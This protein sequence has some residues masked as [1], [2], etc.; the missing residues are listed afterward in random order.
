V[1]GAHSHRSRAS[2]STPFW[3]RATL[4]RG[5]DL[6]ATN[7][8][9][10]TPLHEAARR[11]HRAIILLLLKRGANLNARNSKNQ[12]ARELACENGLTDVVW[13]VYPYEVG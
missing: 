11:S 9:D 8:A 1:R 6:T 2:P 10:H 12:T 5:A 4:E 7:N 13:W 3:T